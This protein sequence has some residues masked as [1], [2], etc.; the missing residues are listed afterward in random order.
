MDTW[1]IREL[2]V[3]PHKPQVLHTDE[4]TRLI[5]IH[6]PAGEELADHQ[7]HESAYL[8]VAGGEVQITNGDGKESALGGPGLVAHFEP[9]ERHAVRAVSD[10]RL[11]LLLAPWPGEGHPSRRDG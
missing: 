8:M 4:D 9:A 2:D 5:A 10:A 11:L 3:Q 1:N 6:L 7:V